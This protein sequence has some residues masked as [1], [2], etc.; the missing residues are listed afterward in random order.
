[1]GAY[2]NSEEDFDM[3]ASGAVAHSIGVISGGVMGEQTRE[4]I[5]DVR[6]VFDVDI[7]STE[8]DITS[9]RPT[10]LTQKIRVEEVINYISVSSSLRGNKVV[11]SI[12]ETIWK[13]LAGTFYPLG[14]LV[15]AAGQGTV[16]YR[17]PAMRNY[18]ITVTIY[19][20]TYA[21][22]YAD[23]VRLVAGYLPD[24]RERVAEIV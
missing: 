20:T 2:F 24:E 10:S 23:S 11:V 6:R 22:A 1:M 7:T 5:P 8:A 15:A 19:P 17:I 16:F 18:E 4:N 12:G 21:P 13:Q 9:R 14:D 3:D